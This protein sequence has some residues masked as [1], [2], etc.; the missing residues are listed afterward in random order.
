MEHD[1]ELTATGCPI[2]GTRM[3]RDPAISLIVQWCFFCGYGRHLSPPDPTIY[4]AAYARHL[5]AITNTLRGRAITRA[6]L[7]LAS[8]IIPPLGTVVEWGCGPGVLLQTMALQQ[9]AIL[10]G[11]DSSPFCAKYWPNGNHKPL[12]ATHRSRE[13]LSLTFV[14]QADLLPPACDVA[15]F[16]DSLEHVDDPARVIHRVNASH[17]LVV[18]PTGEPHEWSHSRHFKVEPAEHVHFWSVDGFERW[19]THL[20]FGVR[21]VTDVETRLGRESITTFVASR[22][23]HLNT[24]RRTTFA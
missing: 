4:D 11:Y 16:C 12:N 2:C 13:A 6:R 5:C 10:Y 18:L 8:M 17:L 3:V 1:P 21:C 22:L 14:A 23:E 20:G 24:D 15:I 9:R 7:A 19:L